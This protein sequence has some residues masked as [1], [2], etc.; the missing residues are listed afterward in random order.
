MVSNA[1]FFLA[2]S[3]VEESMLFRRV[4]Q[5]IVFW[6]KKKNARRIG[7]ILSRVIKQNFHIFVTLNK[8]SKE[9]SLQIKAFR[10]FQGLQ[11]TVGRGFYI[12]LHNDD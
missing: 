1:L 2:K 12:I 4:E 7:K 10:I 8:N 5:V 9:N 3:L 6:M 11:G